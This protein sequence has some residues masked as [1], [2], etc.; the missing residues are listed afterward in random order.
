MAKMPKRDESVK[1][2]LTARYILFN[3]IFTPNMTDN[4][5]R[6]ELTIDTAKANWYSLILLVPIILLFALPY[7]LIWHEHGSIAAAI[8]GFLHSKGGLSSILNLLLYIVIVTGGIVVHEL[9][10]GLTWSLFSK[11]GFRSIRFGIM[12]ESFTPYCHCNEPLK[13]N[14]Y[15]LGTV[16]PGIVLGIIPAVIAIIIGNLSLLVF[17]IFFSTAASGDLLILW[18]LRHETSNTVV[19][20]HP[21]KI[22]CIVQRV[23]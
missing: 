10:H 3:F 22:G 13:V 1:L 14:H 5:T 11:S 6:Q 7:Y 18:V 19:E 9:I 15:R 8:K 20:D 12:R 4:P 16:M 2:K 17:G 23:A 21:S